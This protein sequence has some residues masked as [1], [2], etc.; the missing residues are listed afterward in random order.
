MIIDFDLK[1][2]AYLRKIQKSRSRK[3]RKS[4]LQLPRTKSEEQAISDVDDYGE[5]CA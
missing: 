5:K 3:R 2:F 4:G 1:Y